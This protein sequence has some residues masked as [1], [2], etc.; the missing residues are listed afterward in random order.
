MKAICI[1]TDFT[2]GRR[3]GGINPKDKNLPGNPNWQNSKMG[4][5]I[6]LVKNGDV[7]KYEG[8]EGVEIL[9]GEAAIN[10]K[11]AEV[12]LPHFGAF[13]DA[14]MVESIRQKSVI[15]ST[16]PADD[17]KAL[18]GALYELGVA[19]IRKSNPPPTAAELAKC[20]DCVD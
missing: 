13:N 6:R 18:L 15:L 19:G 12:H 10:A 2:T 8:V 14:L 5:E 16:L 7:S 1:K 17:P 3:A 9:D 20:W 4:C 11:V